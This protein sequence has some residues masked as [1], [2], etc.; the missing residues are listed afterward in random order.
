MECHKLH[1]KLSRFCRLWKR[2]T[3]FDCSS[4]GIDTFGR[5]RSRTKFIQFI[6]YAHL[7]SLELCDRNLNKFSSDRN[8]EKKFQNKYVIHSFNA[9]AIQHLV[10]NST[11]R[12]I[13][14]SWC[15]TIMRPSVS[16]LSIHAQYTTQ[17]KLADTRHTTSIKWSLLFFV[18]SDLLGN[19]HSQCMQL[20]CCSLR[21][22]W[23]H[24]FNANHSPNDS[25]SIANS[26]TRWS[27]FSVN[28]HWI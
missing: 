27:I 1:K 24:N 13:K 3:K 8:D 12:I 5:V 19:S 21:C 14:Q 6:S 17:N 2:Q 4:I 7:A 10:C 26:H 25:H 9:F 18:H 23:I 20:F 15:L 11:L 28:W 22:S 16:T